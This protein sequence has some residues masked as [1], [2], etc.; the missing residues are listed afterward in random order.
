MATVRSL[1]SSAVTASVPPVSARGESMST[2]C[3]R[4]TLTLPKINDDGW[5]DSDDSGDEHNLMPELA[6]GDTVFTAM[7]GGYVPKWSR[8]PDWDE[9]VAIAH[10]AADYFASKLGPTMTAANGALLDFTRVSD[11]VVRDDDLPSFCK[12]TYWATRFYRPDPADRSEY[13]I[14]EGWPADVTLCN[15][16]HR[17]P[18]HCTCSAE[19]TVRA[20]WHDRS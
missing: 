7:T 17:P 19:A 15:V 6:A 3:L 1:P 13:A 11:T 2:P 16:C 5:I 8:L 14:H 4:V 9:M 12:V 18:R 10:Q 20:F